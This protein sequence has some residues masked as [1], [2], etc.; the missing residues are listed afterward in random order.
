MSQTSW[1][2]CA[3]ITEREWKIDITERVQSFL[4]GRTVKISPAQP[5]LAF[6]VGQ[7]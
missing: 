3:Q 7:T 1:E 2:A 6:S 4:V 5:V